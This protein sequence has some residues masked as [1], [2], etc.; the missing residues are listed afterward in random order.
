M[1]NSHKL[2]IETSMKIKFVIFSM[3]ISL[4]LFS[5]TTSSTGTIPETAITPII[6]VTGSGT[7]SAKPDMAEIQFG[8]QAVSSNPTEAVSKN[9]DQMNAVMNVLQSLNIDDADIQTANY[10]MWI[11][12]ISD[13]NGNPTGEQRYHVTNQVNVRLR[14]LAQIGALLEDVINAGVNNVSGITFGVADTKKLTQTAMDNALADAQQ[15]AERMAEDLG[16][17]LGDVQ[18]IIE[19][20]TA[21]S[22][23]PIFA[24]SAIASVDSVPIA[25]GQFTKIVQ[26]QV[27]FTIE[28]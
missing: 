25:E 4:F 7:A 14:D 12:A 1:R 21:S 8:V 23:S 15:K 3:L 28:P 26:V 17:K 6:S 13:A 24:E 2:R 16:V 22:P 5:C 18:S 9:T 19:P 20:G 27:T 10:S 11:E